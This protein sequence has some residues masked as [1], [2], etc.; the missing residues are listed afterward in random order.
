VGI[1]SADAIGSVY[2]LTKL[3]DFSGNYAAASACAALAGGGRVATMQNQN[4]VV[5]GLSAAGA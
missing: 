3:G 1:S 2:N 5:I 4:G